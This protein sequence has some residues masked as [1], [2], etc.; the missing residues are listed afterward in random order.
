MLLCALIGFIAYWMT[1][2]LIV[3]G[4]LDE[5]TRGDLV[6]I[7]YGFLIIWIF[8]VITGPIVWHLAG[9]I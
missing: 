2:A 6:I 8:T 9:L 7:R 3:A 5:P 1:V 4:R